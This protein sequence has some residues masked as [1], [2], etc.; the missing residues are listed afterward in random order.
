M[1][2]DHKSSDYGHLTD[3]DYIQCIKNVNYCVK[4]LIEKVHFNRDKPEN[5]NIYI[6]SIKGKYIMVYENGKWV[7]KN[8]NSEVDDLYENNELMLENWYDEC[9][10]KYPYIITSFE[11]YLKN[12]EDIA[13][14][15]YIKDELMMML[16]N[17]RN[18]V[19]EY[20]PDC[21]IIENELRAIE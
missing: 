17:N 9:N 6:S 15:N 4:T 5:M 14:F 20:N 2:L 16:Y 21:S 1:L 3:S 10:K 12:K 13:E 18:I 11:K 19:M 8:R 7:I